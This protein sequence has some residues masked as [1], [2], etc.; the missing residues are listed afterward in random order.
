MFEDK[1]HLDKHKGIH[2]VGGKHYKCLEKVDDKTTEC[3]MVSSAKGSLHAHIRNKHEKVV[4]K[5]QYERKAD[6]DITW[7]RED[8]YNARMEAVKELTTGFTVTDA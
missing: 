8:E 4:V 2:V 1:H 3:G 7:K 6:Q 5:S